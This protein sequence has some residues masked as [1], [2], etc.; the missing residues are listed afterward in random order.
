MCVPQ[1]ASSGVN[2]AQNVIEGIGQYTSNRTK[3]KIAGMEGKA[4]IDASNYEAGRVREEG[5]AFLG[6]QRAI[7]SA[8]GVDIASGSPADVGAMS[9]ANIEKDALLEEYRGKREAWA[10]GIEMNAYKRKARGGLIQ[11]ASGGTLLG[12]A[13][14][15][16]YGG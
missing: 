4:A 15:A 1:A 11:A 12:Q 9:A 13:A 3:A 2:L 7:Q 16:W 14:N 6:T 10:K 5:Q 8:S